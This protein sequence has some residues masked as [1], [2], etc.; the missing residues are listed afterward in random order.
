VSLVLGFER[1]LS[2]GT[3]SYPY[4][5]LNFKKEEEIEITLDM[6]D[7]ARMAISPGLEASYSGQFFEVVAKLFKQ[8]MSIN[9]IVPGKFKTQTNHSSL[10]CTVGN[11]EGHLFLLNTA[12]IFI[13]K[14]VIY[15]RLKDISLVNFHRITASISMRN[16][17]FEVITKS[18]YTQV[19]SAVDKRE[20]EQVMRYFEEAD[21][22]VKSIKEVE[23]FADAGD[24]DAS[25]SDEPFPDSA[26]EGSDQANRKRKE[27]RRRNAQNGN[28][29]GPDPDES[30]DLDDDFV[31]PDDGDDG[32]EEDGD[33]EIDE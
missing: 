13:K 25:Q 3:T 29:E 9:I 28:R 27:R 21:V 23:N 11:Q 16:F 14:P 18:G 8:I 1:P 15:I 31:A 30:E 7:E 20:L 24:E 5:I 6:E 17:D 33:F 26:D 10:K 4:I 12:L 22:A 32:E 2:Q 19:F